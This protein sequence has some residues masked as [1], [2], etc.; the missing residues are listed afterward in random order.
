MKMLKVTIS[1]E[2]L[3]KVPRDEYVLFTLLQLL[4]SE[5]LLLQKL[6]ILC[7]KH[8]AHPVIQTAN[9]HQ[10]L[11]VLRLLAGKVFEGWE[12]IRTKFFGTGIS[13]RYEELLTQ[14]GKMCLDR[15][16]RNQDSSFPE[17]CH[18]RNS[19]MNIR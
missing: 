3:K 8:D 17:Q 1:A 9:N 16:Q 11:T 7:P 15:D 18:F 12:L 4:V 19:T 14:E 2:E 13:K 10:I 6:L 5:I